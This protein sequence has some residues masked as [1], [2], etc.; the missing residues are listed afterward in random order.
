MKDKEKEKEK[1]LPKLQ[2]NP[3]APFTKENAQ[4]NDFWY[5]D[6]FKKNLGTST[7]KKNKK[8]LD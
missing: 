8:I 5:N 3:Y 2:N 7:K 1:D 4:D 6:K